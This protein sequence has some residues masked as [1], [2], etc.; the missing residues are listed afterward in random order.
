M[1]LFIR[2]AGYVGKQSGKMGFA[3]AKESEK[4]VHKVW[5]FIPLKYTAGATDFKMH[6]G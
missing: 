1:R 6:L 2:S 3:R 4:K 5:F